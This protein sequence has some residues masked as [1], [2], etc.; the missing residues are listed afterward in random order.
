M[1]EHD[2]LL[3]YLDAD[4]V[5]S[6]FDASKSRLV[7]RDLQTSKRLKSW[8]ELRTHALGLPM[9]R[10]SLCKRTLEDPGLSW[11][12]MIDSDMG[13]SETV[14]DDLLR[15][16]DP[17]LRPVIGALCFA[18]REIGTDGMGG[19]HTYAAP[20]ILQWQKH[21]DGVYRF[22]GADHYPVNTLVRAG[23][24]GGACLLI[25][26]SVLERVREKFGEEWFSQE[27]SGAGEVQSEDISFCERLFKLQIPLYVDTGTRTTHA[28]TTWVSEHDFWSQKY[29]PPAV[30]RV[31]VI[32]PVLH[33]PRNV[34]TL[35]RSLLAT[36]GRAT[37]WFVCDPSDS[38]EIEAV[39]KE[40]G[41]VLL[42]PGTFSQKVNFAFKKTKAPWIF[43]C[44]DDVLFRPSWLDHAQDIA[45]RYSAQ[46]VG[47]NDLV[48]P[49][50]M[51]GQHATHMLI[52]R[53][54]VLTVGSSWDGPGVVC[55]E[56]YRHWYVDDE[57]VTA[58][59]SQGVFQMA[60]GSQVEHL[61]PYFNPKVEIDDVY[62]KGESSS[63]EDG[64]LFESRA[65][66]YLHFEEE[67]EAELVEV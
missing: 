40:G 59:K 47:T 41:N 14:L 36:T 4:E 39:R 28:K 64:E 67:V 24:T 57:I 52:S 60:L 11:L 12:L 51:S 38:E 18:Q 30:Q 22:T 32:V 49:R 20:V 37:A 16:A 35:M 6:S 2:V 10:N 23:A 33:R 27:R 63:T 9:S 3:G 61:H 43:L 15:S 55:H 66:K 8:A 29:A 26:R 7:V 45:R 54:Y 48:N 19:F 1:P 25:H 46:V 44:G 5:S 50:V 21:E 65:R 53:D 34:P 58:A 31:D 56:G 62:R 42:H 13:F 17:E